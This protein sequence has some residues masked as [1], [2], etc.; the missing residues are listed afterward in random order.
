MI[1]DKLSTLA[2]Q[3]A[4]NQ[5][6]EDIRIGLG[7]TCVLL[8]NNA[9]GLAYT[10][11]NELGTCC[12]VMQEAGEL[13]GKSAKEMISWAKSPH[14]LKAAIGI[15]TINA[16]LHSDLH[17]YESGNIIDEIDVKPKETFG[18]VGHF[19]PILTKVRNLTKNIYI[20]EKQPIQ[21]PDVYPD[22]AIEVYLPKC[23]VVLITATSIINKTID[24][25]LQYCKKARKIYIVG[26]STPLCPEAFKEYGVTILAGSVVKN[27]K[28]ALEIISQGGGTMAMKKVIDHVILPIN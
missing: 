2:L 24:T 18:M 20:F 28:K 13:I 3:H 15:A 8:D 1:V 16:I 10:F 23:D 21:E 25:L 19:K 7:Y 6:I 4:E 22:S 12:G 14:L 26:P 5:K 11:R 9:C 27:H 17:S